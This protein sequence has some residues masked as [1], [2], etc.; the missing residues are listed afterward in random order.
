LLYLDDWWQFSFSDEVIWLREKRDYGMK[1]EAGSFSEIFV[2]IY[3]TISGHIPEDGNIQ[4]H[5]RE[6]R[7]S[8]LT[9]T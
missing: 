5:R 3:Q 1:T 7:I 2:R 4:I 6:Q 8:D 9:F